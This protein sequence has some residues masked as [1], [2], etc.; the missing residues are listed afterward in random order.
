MD[1]PNVSTLSFFYL[2]VMFRHMIKIEL[3]VINIKLQTLNHTIRFENEPKE[4]KIKMQ[5]HFTI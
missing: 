3:T 5:K 1:Q 4:Q 2:F